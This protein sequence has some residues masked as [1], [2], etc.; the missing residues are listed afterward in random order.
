MSLIPFLDF[1]GFLGFMAASI[2]AYKNF[3]GTKS[4]SSVWILFLISMVF[5]AAWSLM[6]SLEWFG[7]YPTILDEAEESI[8]PIVITLLA[9]FSIISYTEIIKPVK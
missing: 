7:V 9:V 6:V 2:Y 1:I 3:Q 8:F 5:A 4:I